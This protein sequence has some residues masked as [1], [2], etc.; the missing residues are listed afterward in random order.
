M[1]LAHFRQNPAWTG[2]T[3]HL[4]CGMG[5]GVFTFALLHL[6]LPGYAGDYYQARQE[7][8]CLCVWQDPLL[9]LLRDS[10][11]SVAIGAGAVMTVIFVWFHGRIARHELNHGLQVVSVSIAI[12]VA[13][14]A[15][16]C[17]QTAY[18]MHAWQV[19]PRH[20]FSGAE[21]RSKRGTS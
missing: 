20:G 11:G 7:A 14:L 18:D 12:S 21:S 6:A 17:C 5:T 4:L 3:V 1:R 13:L 8:G 10:T 16:A 15:F 2:I 19:H 9:E